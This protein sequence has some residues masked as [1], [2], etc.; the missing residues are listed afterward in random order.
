MS[1][2]RPLKKKISA[3]EGGGLGWHRGPGKREMNPTEQEE[4]KRSESSS[5]GP[6]SG[7]EAGGPDRFSNRA[8]GGRKGKKGRESESETDVRRPQRGKEGELRKFILF[9]H[10]METCNCFSHSRNFR[11]SISLLLK[12]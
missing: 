1:R 12:I 5:A 8:K 2:R 7:V 9:V 11:D 10:I 3:G 6:E 4:G